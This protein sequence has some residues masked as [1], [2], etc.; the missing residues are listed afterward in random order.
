MKLQINILKIIITVYIFL[1]T[2]G[3]ILAAGGS[4]DNPYHIPEDTALIGEPIYIIGMILV[5]LGILLI[6]NNKLIKDKLNS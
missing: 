1:S 2:T 6:I 4:T 3:N 5:S